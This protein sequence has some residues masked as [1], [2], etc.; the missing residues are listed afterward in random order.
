MRLKPNKTKDFSEVQKEY[1]SLIEDNNSFSKNLTD[2]QN[3][4]KDFLRFHEIQKKLDKF[5]YANENTDLVTLGKVNEIAQKNLQDKKDELA[6]KQLQRAELISKTK[7][8]EKIAIK[9][10]NLLKNMGFSSFE[11]KLIN[12]EGENQKGQYQIKG[13]DGNIRRITALSKGWRRIL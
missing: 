3:K 5:K 10:S 7:D 1:D 2:E 13:H 12:D 11:L 6:Q 4:A 8:E 9:I